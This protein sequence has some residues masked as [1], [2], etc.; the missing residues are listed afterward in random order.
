MGV[1]LSMDALVTREKQ[2][3]I[4]VIFAE[5]GPIH[6]NPCIARSTTVCVT[7][8]DFA[9]S[10]VEFCHPDAEMAKRDIPQTLETL[11]TCVMHQL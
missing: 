1:G 6:L 10:A 8:Q 2:S 11:C 5:R 4:L 9:T 7:P 3:Y